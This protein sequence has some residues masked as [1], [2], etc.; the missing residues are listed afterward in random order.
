MQ[1]LSIGAVAQL[2]QI[3][4][5]TLRKWE[6]RHGIAI[7]SR[8]DTGRRVYTQ[9]QVEQLKLIKSLISEGHALA[10]LAQLDNDALRQLAMQHDHTQPR[11]TISSLSLIG[12]NVSR[13]LSAHPTVAV[14]TEE[15]FMRWRAQHSPPATEGLVAESETLPETTVDALIAIRPSF[16]LMIVIYTFSSRRT[17]NRLHDAGITT[18]Q[19]PI[20]D[21]N[22]LVYLDLTEPE[23]FSVTPVRFSNQELARIAA[24][25]PGLQCECPNH[26]AKL[27][28]DI[29]SFE[30]YSMQCVDSDPTEREL[31][32]KLGAISGQA[33]I[34]FEQALI[35]VATADGLPISLDN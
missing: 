13:L 32:Q 22:I 7:P 15:D 25:S 12:P 14:R 23:H 31:H 8:T 3:P 33:R 29:T 17:L 24:L 5:H 16:K 9:A 10:H 11:T 21:Q 4:A 28:M 27:L 2:T 34:L 35:A 1:Q 18:V 20:S 6:S 19:G 30:K 26:I